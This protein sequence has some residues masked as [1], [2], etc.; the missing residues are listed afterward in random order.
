MRM[1]L[2]S[3]LLFGLLFLVIYFRTLSAALSESRP[4]S[5]TDSDTTAQEDSQSLRADKVDVAAKVVAG[6]A[7]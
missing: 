2:F 3:G 4:V 5:A 7:S 6:S 1:A